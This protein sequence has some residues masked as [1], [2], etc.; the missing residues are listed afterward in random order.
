MAGE[1]STLDALVEAHTSAR[2]GAETIE[3]V[4]NIT[5]DL[6]IVEPSFE[7]DGIY[8]ATRSGCMRIDVFMDGKHAVSE[9][10][11]N[12]VGWALDGGSS[13]T[14]PQPEEGKAILLHGLEN[15]T[16]LIGLHE[17]KARHHSLSVVTRST[18]KRESTSVPQL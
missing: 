8:S 1:T 16:R 10:V 9:G 2:G 18:G 4:Q 5:L 12:G 14:R 13:S 11:V 15:P 3:A 17:F 7:L 6:K